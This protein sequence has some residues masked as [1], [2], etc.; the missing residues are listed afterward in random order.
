M[1][2]Y[3]QPECGKNGEVMAGETSGLRL[4]VMALVVLSLFA[5]LFGR[6]WFLQVAAPPNLEQ[7]VLARK[8]RTVQLNPMRGR[9]LD[10]QGRVLADNRRVLNIVVDRKQIRRDSVRLVM[11]GR[12]AGV[13]DTA[14]EELEKRFQDDTLDPLLPLPLAEDITE[15]QAGFVRERLE[16]Y[17]G[18]DVVEA[19]AR[20]YR[21]APIASHIVGFLGRI[22]KSEIETLVNKKGYL[23]SDTVGRSGIEQQYEDV[24]RGT[25]GFQRFE[26]NAAGQPINQLEG[27]GNRQ[28][29]VPGNDVQL[30]V[31]LDVQ[32]YAEQIVDAELR[33]RRLERPP[34]DIDPA[35]AKPVGLIKPPF[36]SPA[37][38]LVVLDPNNGQVIALAS[39][40]PYDNRWF[41]QPLSDAKVKQLFGTGTNNPL[42]NRPIQGQYQIGSTMKLFTTVASLKAGVL[43]PRARP[44]VENFKGRYIIPNCP[45][46][47]PSGCERRNSGGFRYGSPTL[48]EALTA[49]SDAY[50]YNLGAQLYQQDPKADTLQN[51]LRGFGFGSATGI[52]LPDD[53]PGYVPDAALKKKFSTPDKNG[54]RI[55]SAREG[56][57]YFI[58]DNI[59]LAIGQG[60]LAVTPLQL[61]N[62][63]ATFANG[64]TLHAPQI[65]LAVY[66]AGAARVVGHPERVDLS[67]ATVIQAFDPVTRGTVEISDE[68]RNDILPGLK[69][70]TQGT[71]AAAVCTPDLPGLC[72]DG[73]A[74]AP[75]RNYD[76]GSFPV[77][78]K[79]GTAQDVSQDAWKDTSLFSAFA[80]PPD[81]PP[82]YQVTA[83]LEQSGFGSAAA[84][85]VVR[86]TLEKLADPKSLASIDQS[87]PLDRNQFRAAVL[88]KL[89]DADQE[90]LHVEDADIREAAIGKPQVGRVD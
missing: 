29:P 90:C 84:A 32:Q 11:F 10:R 44:K 19:W 28:E 33:K 21:Y 74:V 3:G 36:A 15:A 60:L 25:P 39:N 38:S 31:D 50:F 89:A 16:D 62:G 70:V 49:S 35:T 77:Y 59:N 4:S 6:L 65:A 13:L 51:E 5:A 17:T 83:I 69:G 86:C 52:G 7:D 57:G 81:Q 79:T 14:P 76:W 82:Q 22:N 85:L 42:L 66:S 26:I 53:Q 45:V 63:Y 46:G 23:R 68:V 40:P 80:G 64:G 56:T 54:K 61:A 72:R 30:A 88:P 41:T 37:G 87:A 27:P 67:A 75:F 71:G 24:L 73:T 2:P 58:G 55:I 47:E 18:V 20:V 1:H 43:D 78:G 12:I 8:V 34:R 48:Q 9:I